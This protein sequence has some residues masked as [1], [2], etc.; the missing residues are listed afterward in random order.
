MLTIAQNKLWVNVVCL[1]ALPDTQRIVFLLNREARR[2][3]LKP[4][5]EEEQHAVR[6]KT[7][8]GKPRRLSCNDFLQDVAALMCW[9]MEKRRRLP[10][11]VARDDDGP[12]IAFELA[13]NAR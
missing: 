2:L 13:R 7:L 10:G 9:D 5:S 1:N 11:N 4:G 3:T 6:W 8:S 12:V